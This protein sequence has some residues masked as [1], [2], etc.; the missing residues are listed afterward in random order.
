LEC[1]RSKATVHML[2]QSCVKDLLLKCSNVEEVV[3][4]RNDED[5]INL[6]VKLQDE[7]NLRNVIVHRLISRPKLSGRRLLLPSRKRSA[8]NYADN[9]LGKQDTGSTCSKR[10]EVSHS[11]ECLSHRSC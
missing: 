6:L 1:K 5:N 4:S 3:D 8:S 9:F 7:N 11:T 2:M 10:W